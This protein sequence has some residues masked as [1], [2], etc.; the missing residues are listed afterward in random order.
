MS[1]GELREG[2]HYLQ[3]VKHGRMV[4]VWSRMQHWMRERAAVVA[5]V[6]VPTPVDPF[7]AVSGFHLAARAL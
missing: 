1:Q 6:H 4:F 5:P 3:R 7:Y 2:D